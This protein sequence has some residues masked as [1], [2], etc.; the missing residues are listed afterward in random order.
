MFSSTPVSPINALEK[1]HSDGI[2]EAYFYC[3]F[4]TSATQ[5]GSKVELMWLEEQSGSDL[6]I[7][8]GW[9]RILVFSGIKR[10]DSK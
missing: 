8:S 9:R 2:T 5:R 3:V 10:K 7:M 6:F 4:L 1:L